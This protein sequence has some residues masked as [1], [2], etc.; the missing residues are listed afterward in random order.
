[1]NGVIHNLLCHVR[2]DGAVISQGPITSPRLD[3]IGLTQIDPCS[4]CCHVRRN[5]AVIYQGPIT[6]PPFGLD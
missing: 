3:C 1:M 6:S 4:I 2:R 5:G